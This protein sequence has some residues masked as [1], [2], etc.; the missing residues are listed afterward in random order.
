MKTRSKQEA[1]KKQANVQHERDS[2]P[3]MISK[4]DN[5]SFSQTLA[6]LTVSDLASEPALA[7]C[8]LVLPVLHCLEDLQP[9]RSFWGLKHLKQH[10]GASVFLT[11]ASFCNLNTTP[12]N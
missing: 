4:S 3:H 7:L 1:S 10:Y 6:R 2:N 11:P 5:D 9:E 8:W 12:L